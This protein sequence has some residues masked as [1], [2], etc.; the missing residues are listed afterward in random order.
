MDKETMMLHIIIEH[1]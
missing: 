1:L